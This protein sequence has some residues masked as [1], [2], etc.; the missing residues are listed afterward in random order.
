MKTKKFTTD[1]IL[2]MNQAIGFLL[3]KPVEEVSVAVSWNLIIIQN[4]I[5]PIIRSVSELGT[6]I[7]RSYYNQPETE[8]GFPKIKTGME[9]Q[10][11]RAEKEL[12]EKTFDLDLAPLSLDSLKDIPGITGIHLMQLHPVIEK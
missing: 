12:N 4:A 1:Q 9:E 6:K 7:N 8:V 2:G 5:R 11:E 3:Q 10:A